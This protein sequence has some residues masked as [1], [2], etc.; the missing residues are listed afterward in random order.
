METTYIT[1]TVKTARKTRSIGEDSTTKINEFPKAGI[2]DRRSKVTKKPGHWNIHKYPSFDSAV[3]VISRNLE[4]CMSANKN[5]SCNSGSYNIKYVNCFP[6][7]FQD[8]RLCNQR[9][10]QGKKPHARSERHY[11]PITSSLLRTGKIPN[12][13]SILF[14]SVIEKVY[15]VVIAIKH[16]ANDTPVSKERLIAAN[17]IGRSR[18]KQIVLKYGFKM[19]YL[20]LLISK[21]YS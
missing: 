19:Q 6:Q 5:C 8:K 9:N 11:R 15:P 7:H 3:L 13:R 12:R 21:Y 20:I 16:M 18:V 17:T 10:N 2:L 4:H 1:T 14:F